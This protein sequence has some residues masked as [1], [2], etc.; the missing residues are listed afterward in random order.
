MSIEALLIVTAGVALGSL[1]K[2]ITGVGG[3]IVAIPVMAAF[4]GVERAVVV[5][6]IPGVAMNA[7]LIWGYRSQA[8]KTRDL[9]VLIATG[10]VGVA[11]GTWALASL[12]D[13]I[14][15][16]FLAL[17]ILAYLGTRLANP[18]FELTPRVTRFASPVVGVGSGVMQG[19][20]GISA[21]LVATY[22][23]GF[24]LPRDAYI[25][26][27]SALFQV[28]SIAQCIAI[29]LLGLYTPERLIESALA[30]IPA[31]AL[32]PLGDRIG[33]RLSITAFNQIVLW[34]LAAL[35]AKLL[36]DVVT[37]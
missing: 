31:V 22:V 7:W 20:T 35:A 4:L 28:F 27:V 6:A 8:H 14:L 25:L 37:S 30:T 24:N 36:Y 33:K 34:S 5:M 15:A 10:A 19:A 32:L 2:G 9:P 1:L 3:P 21:P 11:L 23:H 16:L 13:R 12:D 29:A 17:A 18:E 26:A